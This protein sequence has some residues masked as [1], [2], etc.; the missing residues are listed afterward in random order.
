MTQTAIILKELRGSRTLEEVAGAIGITVA[1]LSC[2]EQGTRIPRDL[3][4]AKLAEYYNEPVQH[5]FF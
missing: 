1:S 3:I 4:K 5:I 2:Y